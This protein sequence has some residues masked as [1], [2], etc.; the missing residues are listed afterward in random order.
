MYQ[1]L[2]DTKPKR[3]YSLK[4]DLENSEK[5]RKKIEQKGIREYLLCGNCEVLLSKYENYA[6][7][8]IYAKNKGNKAI[9]VKQ[10][11]TDDL[12]YFTYEY[13][14]FLYKE[15]KL[16]LLSILWRTII[17][18]SFS[19]PDIETELVEKLRKAIIEQK[20]LPY[21]DFGCL[22]QIILYKKGQIAGGFILDP[23][24]T[25]NENATVLNILI[26]GFLY[27][28][29]LNSKDIK[30][31]KKDFFLKEDGTMKIFGRVL[32]QDKELFKRIKKV[33]SHFKLNEK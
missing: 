22:L 15:F 32:F 8:T 10:S 2:Y 27:S 28:F 18:K 1:N 3:F 7:E 30:E 33:F 23:F 26:D 21:D 29:Y 9:I 17:S 4:I 13:Q 16:F 11:Q 25:K 24:V 12:Q 14:G 19:T 31:S 5:Y 6:A 20:P